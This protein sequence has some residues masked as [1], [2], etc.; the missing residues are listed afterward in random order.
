M[1]GANTQKTCNTFTERA[2]PNTALLCRCRKKKKINGCESGIRMA[3]VDLEF[4][5]EET[6]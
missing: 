2:E 5:A 1:N 6:D 3:A 4:K